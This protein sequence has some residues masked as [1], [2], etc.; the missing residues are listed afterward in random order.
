MKIKKDDDVIVVA[1]KDK[2]KTGKVL[3]AFPR[4]DKVIVAGVNVLKKHQRARKCGQKGQV[5]EKTMPVHVSNVMIVDPDTGKGSRVGMKLIGK[6][7]VRISKKSG[8]EI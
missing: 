2:G 6:K 3:V 7:Y 1:G 8:K 4:E 5:V